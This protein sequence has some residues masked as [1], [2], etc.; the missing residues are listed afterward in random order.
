MKKIL[1]LVFCIYALTGCKST[2]PVNPNTGPEVTVVI[3]ELFSPD[4]DI[5]NDSLT[6]SIDVNHPARIKDWNIQI[7]RRFGGQAAQQRQAAE[8]AEPRQSTEGGEQRQRGQRGP[9][10][11]ASG[12]GRPPAEWKWNGISSSRAG[13]MVQSA[14]DYN[15]VLS[16]TDVFDNNTVFEGIISVGILVRREGDIYR[17]I[18]PSIQFLAESSDLTQVSEED[19]RANSRVLRLIANALGRFPDYRITVEGHANPTAAAGSTARNNSEARLTT[20]SEARARAVVNFLVE[21]HNLASNRFG[22]VGIGTKRTVTEEFDDDE[23]NWKNRR[24][25]FILQR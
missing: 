6:I 16:V 19:R 5:A 7:Q 9:F 22:V 21:N 1:V 2:P 13:E 12:T 11:E 15:F 10:F 14:T 23:E 17:M 18:V 25:E 3:P 20:L 24:V 8:G 4:P